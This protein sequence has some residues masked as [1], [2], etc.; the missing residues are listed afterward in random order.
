MTNIL[1]LCSMSQRKIAGKYV[2]YKWLLD[3]SMKEKKL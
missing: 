2:R 3:Y 1:N